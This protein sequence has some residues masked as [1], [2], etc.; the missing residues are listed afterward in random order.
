MSSGGLSYPQ[1]QSLLTAYQQ[2]LTQRPLL[3]KSLTSGVISCA[4]S[5]LA[6]LATSPSG[7]HISCPHS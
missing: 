6:Q 2:L 5:C 4:G 7:G 3:T 1:A